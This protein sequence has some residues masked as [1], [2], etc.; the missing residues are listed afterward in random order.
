MTP[1]E[2]NERLVRDVEGV[3]K[4]LLPN[5]T[6]VGPE[7]CV[8]DVSG[9]EGKSL[10]VRL[11]GPRAG[12]WCDFAGTDKGDLIDLVRCVKGGS[13][14]DAIRWAKDRCGIRDEGFDSL[15]RR[16]QP[17]PIETPIQGK[18]DKTVFDWVIKERGIK[19]EVAK[20][21]KLTPTG[22]TVIS[23]P[24]I[25]DGK[26]YH[27]KYR[28]L[29]KPKKEAFYTSKDSTPILFGWQAIPDDSRV[30]VL[31]EGEMDA[32][33]YACH[34]I[35][36]LSIPMGAGVGSKQDWIDRDWDRLER[37]DT[38][39]L[40]MDMDDAGKLTAEYLA[41]RLGLHRVRIVDLPKKDANDVLLSGGNLQEYIDK[42]RFLDP[43]ELR[44]A[45]DFFDAVMEAF[46]PTN[47]KVAGCT[48]P[49]EKTEHKFRV[50]PAEVTVW[51]GYSGHGKSMVLSHICCDVA[52]QGEKILIASMEMA[53]PSLLKRM[54][55]QVS[56][57]ELPDEEHLRRIND[58]MDGR[59]WIVNVRGT[60]KTEKLLEIARYAWKRYGVTNM[61]IDSLAKCGLSEDDYN[62][63][64]LFV[65][66]L[67][68][69]AAETGIHIHLVCHSRKGEDE[70]A[71]PGK[72][73]VRGAVA[74]TDMVDN[75]IGVWRNKRKEE[76]MQK[77]EQNG[78]KVDPGLESKPDAIL[79][80]QKQ[81]HVDY[82]GKIALWFDA[83]C[84]LYQGKDQSWHKTI[85][86]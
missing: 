63:Q 49:W 26:C 53:P 37:F 72:H 18:A 34:G 31:T 19:A 11:T 14:G 78:M 84:H 79:H 8:G 33:A 4:E 51:Q 24:C 32:L 80:I 71:A 58:W 38:I 50:R 74:I 77:A 13:I 76:E 39:F 67:A 56:A 54:Y 48:L 35:P 55:Q 47:A 5:G 27:V 62:G 65:E 23:Y 44:S 86:R 73:D 52:N 61:V 85:V 28:D 57:L 12:V 59:V 82:E 68:D 22:G 29:S 45:T 40:S 6:K 60:A 10:K 16:S 83:N 15:P 69:F 21:Y 30:V 75:V 70:M 64:K 7:W 41:K 46:Y 9:A 66:Q 1:K 43:D 17:K 36:A 3:A 81:R 20:A 25:A 42:A 2:I